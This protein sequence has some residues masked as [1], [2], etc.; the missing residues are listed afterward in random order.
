MQ[1]WCILGYGGILGEHPTSTASQENRKGVLDMAMP[2]E[3]QNLMVPAIDT[4]QPR[5]FETASFGLG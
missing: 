4:S 1:P 5:T 3:R 2:V